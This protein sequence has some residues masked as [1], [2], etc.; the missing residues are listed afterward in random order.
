MKILLA[1]PSHDGKIYTE[2]VKDIIR[3]IYVLECN[4]LKIDF[5]E[6]SGISLVT[7]AR[8][9]IATLFLNSDHDKLIFLDSDISFEANDLLQISFGSESTGFK[10]I[11]GGVYPTKQVDVRFTASPTIY[12][13]DQL[14]NVDTW[15][16]MDSMPLG[17]S[18]IDREVFETL[19]PLVKSYQVGNSTYR[20]FFKTYVSNG[21]LIGED[22]YF[23]HLT[24]KH[25]HSIYCDPDIQLKHLGTYAYTANFNDALKHNNLI[26]GGLNNAI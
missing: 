26:V 7:H 17:F 16:E 12:G 24:K 14:R 2:T 20:E 15:I 8:N 22:I 25:G 11:H 3:S 21:N 10:G 6:L 4:G 13:E 18:C 9:A 5:T 1:V 23:C 19:A